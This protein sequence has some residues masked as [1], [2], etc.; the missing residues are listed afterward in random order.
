MTLRDLPEKLRDERAV[1]AFIA[2]IVA[3]TLLFWLDV[4]INH[5]GM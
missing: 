1:L 2:G 4:A 5:W 3:A